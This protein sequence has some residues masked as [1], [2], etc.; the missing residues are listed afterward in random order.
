MA[1]AYRPPGVTVTE[2][3][4]PSISALLAVP[5]SVGLVGLAQG[6]VERTDQI[7]LTGTGAHSLSDEGNLPEDAT[8]VAVTRVIDTADRTSGVNSDG[9]YRGPQDGKTGSGQD[10][11]LD[12]AAKTITRHELDDPDA[13]DGLIPDGRIVAVTYRYVP[14]NYFDAYYCEDLATVQSRYGPAWKDGAIYSDL[15]Y[16][17]AAA[18]ENG[19]RFVICQ[20]LFGRTTPGDANTAKVAPVIN[21]AGIANSYA[22]AA[23]W[24][25]TLYSLRDIEDIN[26]FVPV[27]GQSAAR[28]VTNGEWLAIIQ[29]FQ[30]HIDW[31]QSQY[32]YAVL[33]CGEDG[34]DG[35]LTYSGTTPT[36][37]TKATI[38]NDGLT[39]GQRGN[40]G[41]ATVLV[42]TCK[43]PRRTPDSVSGTVNVGG[44]YM[45]AALAGMLASYA[46][47]TPLTR[48]PVS[49]FAGVNDFRSRQDKNDDA[50]AGLLVVESR[51]LAVTVR[52]AI[53]TDTSGA[54]Q[55]SELSVVRAKHFM[56]ESLRTTLD[57][58]VIGTMIADANAPILI[59]TVVISVLENLRGLRALVDYANVGVRQL[60]G[61]PTT[62]EVRFSYRPA[63]PINYVNLVFSIDLTTGDLTTTAA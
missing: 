20:P 63:F 1:L 34:T 26:V 39:L 40:I 32:Q 61:Q 30:S 57:T 46:V 16:A 14:A 25:D 33:L 62:I 22:N 44:Q 37:P 51:G 35:N 17:A 36:G 59:K 11:D 58:Q 47:S 23:T 10:F 54:S 21:D 56:V 28:K 52:H 50:A 45:A 41:E 49:G 27:V 6:Y 31:L 18:F 55:K 9:I 3:S 13:G 15:T 29:T 2:E 7:K 19:A 4:T 8:L 24:A 5:A 38:R 43:F 12:L 53:T 48:K 60:A 42:N